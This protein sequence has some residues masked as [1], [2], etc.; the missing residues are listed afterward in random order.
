MIYILIPTFNNKR[1]EELIDGLTC[2]IEEY[3]VKAEVIVLNAGRYKIKKRANYL[4]EIL[5]SPNDF[6][7]ESVRIGINECKKISNNFDDFI[8]LLNDDLRLSENYLNEVNDLTNK[9]P[10]F[11]LG[12]YCKTV[13]DFR[14]M[15]IE[16]TDNN[17]YMNK[18]RVVFESNKLL[19]FRFDKIEL[20]N[21]R[22]TIIPKKYFDENKI[23]VRSL[24][25]PHYLGDLDIAA[26]ALKKRIPWRRCGTLIVYSENNYGSN[27]IIRNTLKRYIS[28]RSPSRILSHLTF[29][30]V[31]RAIL[32]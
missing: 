10:N 30:I 12:S 2:Q 8:L 5:V 7:T 15:N 19:N 25:F 3:K 17:N 23:K 22:G 20:F 24:L 32:R 1:I 11:I 18:L 4:Q 29:I 9:F 6:W 31:H 16:G 13:N 27:E 26:Q 21:G 28:K 14:S